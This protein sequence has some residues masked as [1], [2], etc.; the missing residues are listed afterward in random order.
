MMFTRALRSYAVKEG[1]LA[2]IVAAIEDCDSNGRG[3]RVEFQKLQDR[4]AHRILAVGCEELPVLVA[5]SVEGTPSEIWPPS[6]ALQ[7]LNL[8]DLAANDGADDNSTAAAMVLGM[9]GKSH[10]SLCITPARIADVKS[11]RLL[12][13]GSFGFLFESAG[14]LKESPRS[15]GH[16]YKLGGRVRA[17]ILSDALLEFHFG[18]GRCVLTAAGAD[19]HSHASWQLA[20]RDG[21]LSLV[22]ERAKSAPLPATARWSYAITL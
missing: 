18:S 3:L 16:R 9:S 8:D 2:P 7:A 6:P 21:I 13:M 14:R 19:E 5:E 22:V 1:E 15:L 4:Y 17:K 20:N 11:A 12:E 10:W